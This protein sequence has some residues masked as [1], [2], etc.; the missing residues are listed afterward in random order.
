M[1]IDW[2]ART[3]LIVGTIFLQAQTYQYFLHRRIS[4]GN[5]RVVF[6]T[7]IEK[8]LGVIFPLQHV[9]EN[10][11]IRALASNHHHQGF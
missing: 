9:I 1:C 7:E 2:Y 5:H 10:D 4:A 11:G 8:P 3:R 6:Q